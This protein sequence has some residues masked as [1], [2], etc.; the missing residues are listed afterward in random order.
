LPGR[1]P[2]DRAQTL[3]AHAGI[4]FNFGLA[5]AYD[6]IAS[7]ENDSRCQGPAAPSFCTTPAPTPWTIRQQVLTVSVNPA[8]DCWRLDLS[9][10]IRREFIVPD[11]RGNP[12][13]P[14]KPD[15]H[16]TLTIARFGS[17]GLQ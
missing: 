13:I 12:A 9:F 8:C 2:F 16:A 1:K 15:F 10:L 14:L 5:L 3:T 17:F 7:P 11:F 6:L 4:K